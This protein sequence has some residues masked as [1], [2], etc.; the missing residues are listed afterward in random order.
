MTRHLNDISDV[1]AYVRPKLC[2]YYHPHM[3]TIGSYINCLYGIEGC[4]CGGL[5]HILLD[6][7]NIKDNDILFCLK[8]CLSHP[9]KEE[10]RIGQLICE[11]YLKLNIEQRSVLVML[12]DFFDDPTCF[13]FKECSECPMMHHKEKYNN[14]EE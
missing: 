12:M 5:L 10:A 11:E 2:K 8:E 14:L 1:T 4:G 7:N 13:E 3:N 9:E 6:D